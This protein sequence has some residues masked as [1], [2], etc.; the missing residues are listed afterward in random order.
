MH[1]DATLLPPLPVIH[2]NLTLNRR[3]HY[4]LRTLLRLAVE[5]QKDRKRRQQSKL[6]SRQPAH[7]GQAVAS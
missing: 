3:E 1:D 7:P 5:A 2:E 4:R 6:D